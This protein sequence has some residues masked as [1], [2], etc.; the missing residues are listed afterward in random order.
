MIGLI[1]GKY[2]LNQAGAIT[3]IDKND[4]AMITPGV[5]PA[6]EQNG[7]AYLVGSLRNQGADHWDIIGLDEGKFKGIQYFGM[8]YRPTVIL[9]LIVLRSLVE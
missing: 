5:D 2:E 8:D 1:G 7:L 4:F 3:K 6:L 9:A